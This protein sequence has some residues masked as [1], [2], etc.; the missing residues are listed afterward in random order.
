MLEPRF[1]LP[2]ITAPSQPAAPDCLLVRSL[3]V[4]AGGVVAPELFRFLPLASLAQRFMVLPRLQP[5]G[6]RLQL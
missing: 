6:A 1:G 3:D 5:D 2:D 4:G